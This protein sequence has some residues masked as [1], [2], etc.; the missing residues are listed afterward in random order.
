MNHLSCF[1][2]SL[3]SKKHKHIGNNCNLLYKKMKLSSKGC[4]YGLLTA[5]F[6]TSSLGFMP[7]QMRRIHRSEIFSSNEIDCGCAPVV[8]FSGKPP[9]KVQ[10]GMNFRQIGA[11]VPIFDLDGNQTSMNEILD[12]S[13]TSLVVFLRSLG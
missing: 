8:E 6:V 10:D 13:K 7:N 1:H 4:F 11:H 2:L 3:F 12:S 5:S 9:L